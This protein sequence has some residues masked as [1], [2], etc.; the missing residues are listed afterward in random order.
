MFL[1][2]FLFVIIYLSYVLYIIISYNQVSFFF[3]KLAEASSNT[4]RTLLA[5][6]RS[7]SRCAVS[8]IDFWDTQ[9]LSNQNCVWS[10]AY[11]YINNSQS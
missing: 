10:R 2:L 4:S 8:D 11:W 5:G 9:L 7:L 1:K 3:F 6:M